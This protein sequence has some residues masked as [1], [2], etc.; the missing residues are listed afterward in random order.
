MTPARTTIS[1]RLFA[2]LLPLAAVLATATDTITLRATGDG[3]QSLPTEV[4]WTV[5][6]SAAPAA[7]PIIAGDLVY[8]ALQSGIVEARRASDGTELWRRDIRTEAPLAADGGRVFIA[9]GSA[10]YALNADGSAGW[11]AETGVLT[12]PILAHDGWVIAATDTE[13]TALRASDGSVVWRLPAGA[14]RERPTIEGAALFVSTK[15][16]RLMALDLAT[17]KQKWERRFR[18]AP[19]EALAFADRVFVGSADTYCYSLH[20][21]NGEIAWRQRTGAVLRGR[22][23]ADDLRVYVV[24]LDNQLRA[25]DRRNGALR[26]PPRG[27]PFRPTTGP[28]V[29]G[30]TVAVAGTTNEIRAFEAATGLPGAVLTLPEAL[31][32]FPAYDPSPGRARIA[33]VTGSL[34]QLWTL[35]LAIPA[36]PTAPVLKLEPLSVLPGRLIP[37][38]RPPG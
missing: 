17:G 31:T 16:G 4:K 32:T 13:L 22:P 35:S 26:W 12:A 5:A 14:A 11:H 21:D 20:A 15:D 30:R 6:L 1:C 23:A 8:L 33:A 25:F 37:I 38:P 36:P 19:T 29:F 27:L 18:G 3:L 2:Q 34:T 7:P 24:G 9:S 10:I 28:V